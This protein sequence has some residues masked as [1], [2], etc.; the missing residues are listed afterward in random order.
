MKTLNMLLF[1]VHFQLGDHWLHSNEY[2]FFLR[3]LKFGNLLH[4]AYCD[5][6]VK[7]FLVLYMAP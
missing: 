2:G 3:F 6:N 4:I 1:A 5:M 7:E